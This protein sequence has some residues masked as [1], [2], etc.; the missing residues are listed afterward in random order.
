ME[1]DTPFQLN[2]SA[3]PTR[4]DVASVASLR[5][6]LDRLN[7]ELNEANEQRAQAAEYGLVLLEEKQSL[8][9]QYEEQN[10]LYESTQRELENS[11]SVSVYVISEH[12]KKTHIYSHA[13]GNICYLGNSLLNCH[14]E[15]S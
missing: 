13:C 10:A 12:V 3:H 2:T 5:E 8:Q 1:V 4:D 9:S 15:W 7:S 14:V 6:E 11:L